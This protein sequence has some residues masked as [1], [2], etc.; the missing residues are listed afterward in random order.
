MARI[1]KEVSA[2]PLSRRSAL[3]LG[4][5]G[6]GAACAAAKAPA[7]RLAVKYHMI[8]VEASV[9]TKFELLKR[10]GFH[11]VEITLKEQALAAELV[12]AS[13]RTGIRVHGVV[14]GETDAYTKAIDLCDAVRG[15]SVLIV[16]REQ[17]GLSYNENYNLMHRH[18]R[19]ALPYAEKKGV[20]LLIENV[21]AS[22]LRRAEE[23]AR[24][25]DSLQSP[26]LGAYLDTGNAITW[27][28]Q[29]AEHWLRVL[30]TRSVKLDIKDRGHRFFGDPDTVSPDAVGTDGG[31]VH[32]EHVRAELARL[33]F[34]GWATAEVKGGDAERLGRMARW[35]QRI[36]R[37][38]A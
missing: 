20:P 8:Q 12:R 32:W 16:A 26:Y 27:T 31:E 25:I 37:L 10:A 4:L 14:H 3:Q 30:G 38:P 34:S 15:T 33:Q 29:S 18:I 1:S 2:A 36:L 17:P 11:G 9:Q 28:D 13:A 24:F 19:M 21:K 22:F 5:L 7:I 35:M 23:M 6:A